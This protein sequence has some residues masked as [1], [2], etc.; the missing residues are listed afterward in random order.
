M[1]TTTAAVLLLIALLSLSACSG[2]HGQAKPTTTPSIGISD[3]GIEPNA[4]IPSAPSGTD[5]A[6]YLTSVRGIDP[7]LRDEE[8]WSDSSLISAGRDACQAIHQKVSEDKQAGSMT[9]RLSTS[10]WTATAGDARELIEAART[11]I[12]PT[13]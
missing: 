5:R 7:A 2:S 4:G 1:R 10:D 12:C 11:H 6:D 8:M 9:M 13:Y 3:L